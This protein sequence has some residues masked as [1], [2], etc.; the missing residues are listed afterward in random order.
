MQTFVL[1]KHNGHVSTLNL[2]KTD[3]VMNRVA[4]IVK[5]AIAKAKEKELFLR[6]VQKRRNRQYQTVYYLEPL[7]TGQG[8][9]TIPLLCLKSVIKEIDDSPLPEA[10]QRR[11][12]DIAERK[13]MRKRDGE[14]P[15]VKFSR[16]FLN[17]L[18]QG[19][20]KGHVN[21]ET[22]NTFMDRKPNYGDF[23]QQLD[24]KRLLAANGLIEGDWERFIRRHERSA[25][26]R[27]T[28]TTIEAFAD[29]R[30]EHKETA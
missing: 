28:K 1:K 16:R 3:E 27:M 18:W 23:H 24:Y 20:G 10:I 7:I 17:A 8:N 13:R 2:G 12:E 5:R 29:G 4:R 25:L 6:I 26:Y 14:Y 15:F 21:I 11:L 22:I 30:R 19:Q 9:T